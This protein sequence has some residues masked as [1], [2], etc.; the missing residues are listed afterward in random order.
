MTASKLRTSVRVSS[1]LAVALAA[2]V[3]LASCGESGGGSAGEEFEGAASSGAGAQSGGGGSSSDGGGPSF[4]GGASSGGDGSGA[5][6]SGAN[7]S[8]ANGGGSE[9]SGCTKVDFLFVID[10]SVSM[11]EQQAALIA[12][13]PSF[14]ET[15]Q[16]TLSASSDYHIMVVDTDAETRCTA[17]NCQS[18]A[19]SAG[20]LCKQPKNGYACANQF[21]ACDTV[22]G[23]GVLHPAGEAASNKLCSFTGGN[24]YIVEGQTNLVDNFA[25]A[26]Q[27]GL[28]G[29]PSER[30]MDAMVAAMADDINS[31]TGCNA[32]FLRSDAIL[33]ISFLSDDPNVEDAGTPDDWY[34]AV[35]DAKGGDPEAVVVLGLTPA[36]D[37]CDGKASRGAHW[38]E[39][40]KLFGDRGL[41]ASI[42]GDDYSPFFEQAV[43][44][45]DETC[46]EFEPP[47]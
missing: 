6:G 25:C 8:G 11:K 47:H 2:V 38:S 4:P 35:V 12:S 28:A 40:V 20:D 22:M 21:E 9:D 43:A 15:I 37:D 39:F 31:P 45:I 3:G 33:V 42:C 24:R 14:M 13:F 10:N 41:E 5:N 16:T 30:P 7:G 17:A 34:Q 23:A 27:V 26:A 46:D 18:G 29:H 19:M 36:F 32:G 1:S 44:V